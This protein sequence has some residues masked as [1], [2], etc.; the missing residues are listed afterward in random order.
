MALTSCTRACVGPKNIRH[1]SLQ[2]GVAGE[3]A[4][5][6]VLPREL[7]LQDLPSSFPEDTLSLNTEPM[8]WLLC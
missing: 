3:V 6:P 2:E 8:L 5:D 4:L 1:T 7:S